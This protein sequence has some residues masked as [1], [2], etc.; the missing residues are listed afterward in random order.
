MEKITEE[1]DWDYG[2][3]SKNIY[4]WD[5]ILNG[6][7]NQLKRGVDF[8]IDVKSFVR[9]A[10][11][12]ARRRGLG[13]KNKKI[14]ENTVVIRAFKYEK[15]EG[16]REGREDPL[17]PDFI[18]DCRENAGGLVSGN[19]L[20]KKMDIS[21]DRVTKMIRVGQE[22]GFIGK[23]IITESNVKGYRI[24]ADRLEEITGVKSP[25]AKP[26]FAEP[27]SVTHGQIANVKGGVY[28][29]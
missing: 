23:K 21:W 5:E 8:E 24:F 7:T 17:Y 16:P 14:D 9:Q 27:L 1:F 15:G 10:R 25:E 18:K 12:I 4:N 20:G 22:D 2:L 13:F 28:V 11:H 6:D 26:A 29:N 19:R 3:H